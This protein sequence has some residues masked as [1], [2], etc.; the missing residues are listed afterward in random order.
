MEFAAVVVTFVRDHPTPSIISTILTFIAVF[1]AVNAIR[2]WHKSKATDRLVELLKAFQEPAVLMALAAITIDIPQGRPDEDR[3]NLSML[4]ELTNKVGDLDGKVTWL[5]LDGDAAQSGVTLIAADLDDL[6]R[7]LRTI[8]EDV[9]ILGSEAKTRDAV[10]EKAL[11]RIRD[12]MTATS[13]DVGLL[14]SEVLAAKNAL[15]VVI[16]NTEPYRVVE[17]IPLVPLLP[18]EYL[19]DPESSFPP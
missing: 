1:R 2:D 16:R 10:T 17:R 5:I 11:Q 4:G 12:N 19:E 3:K 18:P 7:A 8:R 6:Q 14:R 9:E 13:N 15:Y